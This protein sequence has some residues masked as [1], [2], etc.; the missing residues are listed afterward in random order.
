MQVG[1]QAGK[2]VPV[3]ALAIRHDEVAVHLITVQVL[4][5]A[6]GWN[7]QAGKEVIWCL[8]TLRQGFKVSPLCGV[9][10]CVVRG[11]FVFRIVFASCCASRQRVQS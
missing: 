10:G 4:H 6:V 5:W 3:S 11:P 8:G 7:C 9:R 2:G 1:S